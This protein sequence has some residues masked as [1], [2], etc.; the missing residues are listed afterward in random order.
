MK[1]RIRDANK[2]LNEMSDRKVEPDNVTCNTLI[3]A[4]SK[5][6]D[7]VS[8]MKVKK[9]MLEAALKPDQFTFKA[10]IHGF[11][12]LHEV[13]SAKELRCLMLDFLLVIPPTHGL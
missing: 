12:K 6:G 5:I 1:G 9:K 2:L 10:L 13:N 11:Y 3:N 8:A 4:Y 7:M